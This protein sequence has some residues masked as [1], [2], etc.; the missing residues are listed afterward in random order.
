[1]VLHGR[2][3]LH[4]YKNLDLFPPS[5]FDLKAVTLFPLVLILLLFSLAHVALDSAVL[6]ISVH[7]KSSSFFFFFQVLLSGLLSF[8]LLYH[9]ERKW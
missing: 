7:R 8:P 6:C 5:L 3:L 1:M 9:L 2:H 4:S